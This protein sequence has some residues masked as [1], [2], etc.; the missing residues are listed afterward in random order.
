MLRILGFDY[1]VDKTK[2]QGDLDAAGT[3][4]F[5]I[6]MISVANDLS[7]NLTKSTYLHELI[8]VLDYCLNLKLEHSTICQL[9]AGLY[10]VLKDNG[11]D[12]GPLLDR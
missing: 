2:S 9:E 1:D 6:Q 8:E 11:V 5:S 12:L 10:A 3:V 7:C 4:D